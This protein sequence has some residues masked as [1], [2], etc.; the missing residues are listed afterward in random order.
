[1]PSASWAWLPCRAAWRLRRRFPIV[2]WT[3]SCGTASF[4][5]ALNNVVR[6]AEASEVRLRIQVEDGELIISVTDN[7]RGLQP[8][9]E[10]APGMDG[11]ANM[12]ERMSV[13]GGRCEI[14]SAPAQGT[15]VLFGVRLPDDNHD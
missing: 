5:E 11:L 15:T 13:L 8:A 6:H 1:M 14:R 2:R 7:G 3:P 4:K 12:R 9:T 10:T